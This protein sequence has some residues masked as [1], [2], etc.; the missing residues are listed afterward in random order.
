[1]WVELVKH[2]LTVFSGS[3]KKW[4]RNENKA[5]VKMFGKLK[6]DARA[7]HEM[8]EGASFF[9]GRSWPTAVSGFG[10]TEIQTTIAT[11]PKSGKLKTR[12]SQNNLQHI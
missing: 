8:W 10:Q 11:C 7:C 4:W 6:N 9:S 3:Q 2:W 12:N 5:A 1:M